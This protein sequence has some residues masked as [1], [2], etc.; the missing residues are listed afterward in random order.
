MTPIRTRRRHVNPRAHVQV[1]FTLIELLVVVLVLSIL[2]GIAIPA[3]QRYTIRGKMAEVMSAI[4]GC[5]TAIADVYLSGASAPGANAWGCENSAAPNKY[6][7]SV[8]TDENGVVTVTANGFRDPAVDG[9]K[10]Q[11]IPYK[12]ATEKMAAADVGNSI[13]KWAC[14]P[15]SP[16]VPRQYLPKSCSE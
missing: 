8:S 7:A 12:T 5:R 3:Y 13:F 14:E 6:V 2:V 10:I 15:G 9:K 1:G 11:L 4:A 16:G